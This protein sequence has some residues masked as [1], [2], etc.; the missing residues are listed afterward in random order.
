MAWSWRSLDVWPK[1]PRVRQGRTVLYPASWRP[2]G[3]LDTAR[4]GPSDWADRVA[5]WQDRYGVPDR[6]VAASIAQRL[7][8]DISRPGDRHLLRTELE[9]TPDTQLFED[10]TDVLGG[11]DWLDGR[12]HEVTISLF[13]EA[14]RRRAARPRINVNVPPRSYHLPGEDW[15]YFRLYLSS[16]S[17]DTFVAGSLHELM[18]EILS[19]H[20][21]WFYV[22]YKSPEEHMRLRI[23]SDRKT[24]YPG[25]LAKVVGWAREER[26]RGSLRNFDL[27]TYTP[28]TWRYGPGPMMEAAEEVFCSDSRTALAQLHGRIAER[29]E[30]SK[31]D[32]A[33]INYVQMFESLDVPRW[34]ELARQHIAREHVAEVSRRQR[35]KLRQLVDLS[36]SWDTLARDAAGRE[37]IAS[38]QDRSLALARY[39]RLL[40]DQFR[41]DPGRIA[42]AALSLTHMHFNRLCGIDQRA[43]RQ[44]LSLFRELV[45]AHLA[46]TANS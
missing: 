38:W 26:R 30:I 5:R 28:E 22:R 36:G 13:A 46:R 24:L 45:Q 15:A 1:L 25:V 29:L 10:L 27:A 40:R 34:K 3:L 39:G 43:E 19:D 16:A 12:E 31:I 33:A 4:T 35:Q 6:I 9:R 11:N 23:Q 14:E 17:G 32:L 37:L 44:S 20:N 21:Q 7:S 8:L 42:A 41:Y 2:T 18:N